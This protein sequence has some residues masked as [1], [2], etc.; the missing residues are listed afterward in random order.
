MVVESK[1]KAEAELAKSLKAAAVLGGEQA[2][3]ARNASERRLRSSHKDE[4]AAVTL[5]LAQAEAE[6]RAAQAV[7]DDK[8]LCNM[9]RSASVH[10]CNTQEVTALAHEL[11]EV[12]KVN[13]K[14]EKDEAEFNEEL[15]KS[16]EDEVEAAEVELNNLKAQ[17][18]NI[19]EAIQRDVKLAQEEEQQADLEAKL[20]ELHEGSS[21]SETA[22]EAIKNKLEALE[23]ESRTAEG[24]AAQQ[25]LRE[26]VSEIRARTD[27]TV[28]RGRNT[29]KEADE[30]T[31]AFPTQHPNIAAA[32][33]ASLDSIHE[34]ETAAAVA[35]HDV[36]AEE[37]LFPQ[38]SGNAAAPTEST[39]EP[40]EAR[41]EGEFPSLRSTASA[42]RHEKLISVAYDPQLQPPSTTAQL[43]G[44]LWS[45]C[46]LQ[47]S[48]R[49][50]V[51]RNHSRDA[52][53][54]YTTDSRNMAL[55]DANSQAANLLHQR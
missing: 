7:R 45:V 55:A 19:A 28:K 43:C 47:F 42:R 9:L 21:S 39:P 10:Y 50:D 41:E 38:E 16:K 25:E 27:E 4:E 34:T 14:L 12:E 44:D 33:Q 51:H 24:E 8:K 6:S 13:A 2:E 48:L 5:A 15:I 54:T 37:E 53:T 1:G 40:E 30:T 18:H 52:F 22:E 49:L 36:E 32:E 3:Y 17:R 23:Q 20:A 26:K 31:K 46:T 29:L 35:Q 11:G